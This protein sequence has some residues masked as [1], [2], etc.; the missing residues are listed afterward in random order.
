MPSKA[1]VDIHDIFDGGK[2]LLLPE[3]TIVN[4]FYNSLK[5]N[6]SGEPIVERECFPVL[7]VC[8]LYHHDLTLRV[9]ELVILGEDFFL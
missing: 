7:Q 6:R 4:E 3:D 8:L 2:W 5:I 1:K 9:S